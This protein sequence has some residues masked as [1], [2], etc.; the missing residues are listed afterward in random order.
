MTR[1]AFAALVAAIASLSS[2]GVQAQAPA[3]QLPPDWFDDDEW[4]LEVRYIITPE[5]LAV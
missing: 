5:E 2:A 1:V 4:S 3:G